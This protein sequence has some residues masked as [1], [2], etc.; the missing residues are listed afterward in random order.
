MNLLPKMESVQWKREKRISVDCMT[1]KFAF[2]ILCDC[3]KN[4][5]TI[6]NSTLSTIDEWPFARLSCINSELP[7]NDNS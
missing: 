2:F 4:F 7:I 3:H 5:R 6:Q 1:A